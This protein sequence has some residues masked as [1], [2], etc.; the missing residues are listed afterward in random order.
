[1]NDADTT[2]VY[3][4]IRN[5]YGHIS[6]ASSQLMSEDDPQIAEQIRQTEALVGAAFIVLQRV[7]SGADVYEFP[8]G[9][10]VP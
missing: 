3:D 9:V 4:M 8:E 7:R 1:M 6:A 5:A 2:A 10:M